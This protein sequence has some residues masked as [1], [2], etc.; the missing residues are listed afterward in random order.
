M[1]S[2]T[3]A[4]KKRHGNA[5]KFKPGG[6]WRICRAEGCLNRFRARPS[7]VKRG[8]GLFCS[9]ECAYRSRPPVPVERVER[10]R[11]GMLARNRV[12]K[13]NPRYKHGRRVGLNIRG[14][15]ATTKGETCCRSCGKSSSRLHLHHAVPR[16]ICPPDAKRDLRNGITLC[17]SCHVRWHKGSPLPR[18]IFTAEEWA[19]VSRL[20]L[21][22]RETAAWL[23]KHYPEMA[24]A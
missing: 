2:G 22:G 21:E 1:V 12:G 24:H 16:S 6:A 13:A 3:Q 11:K 10:Q 9:R 20:R 8:Q 4:P 18:S 23:D 5:G 7:A 15:N 19:Y 17:G 14:W